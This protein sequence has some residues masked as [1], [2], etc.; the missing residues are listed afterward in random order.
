M[1]IISY[2]IEHSTDLIESGG[3]IVGFLLVFIECF[4]PALPLSVFV[5]LNVNAFGFFIGCLISWCATCLGSYICYRFFKFIESKFTDKFLNKRLIKRIKNNVDRFN[6]I[7]FTELVLILTLPFTPSFLIN[8]LSG[9]TKMNNKKFIGALLIGKFFAIVFW[10]YIGKSL[11]DSLMDVDTLI[12]ILIT[13]II[14]YI[15]SKFVSK[16]LNIE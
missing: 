14:A 2:I 7:K 4:I 16:K 9:V 15:I 10:G 11:I 13:L 12:Y 1:E 8:I 3:M 6:K 5:A